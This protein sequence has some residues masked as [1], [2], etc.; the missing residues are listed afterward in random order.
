MQYSKP[1]TLM[2][3]FS[4]NTSPA[5]LTSPSPQHDS[6]KLNTCHLTASH[7]SSSSP[8][9]SRVILTFPS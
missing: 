2:K 6:N 3:I 5:P 8:T 7:R 1:C 9:L 4:L